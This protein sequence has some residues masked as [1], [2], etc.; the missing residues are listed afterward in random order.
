MTCH[1]CYWL[2]YCKS[3]DTMCFLIHWLVRCTEKKPHDSVGQVIL[4]L[5][6]YE[7]MEAQ[8]DEMKLV[9]LKG[10]KFF[11]L[12]IFLSPPTFDQFPS[13]IMSFCILSYTIQFWETYYVFD[14]GVHV[15]YMLNTSKNENR[16]WS[17][18]WKGACFADSQRGFDL[19]HS[20]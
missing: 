20:M 16:G 2:L 12:Q 9:R 6:L 10:I 17:D 5:F 7:K 18:N 4:V 8:E 11:N 1:F 14:E 15:L 3:T 13:L 19:W